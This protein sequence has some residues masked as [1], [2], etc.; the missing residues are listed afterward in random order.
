MQQLFQDSIYLVTHFGKSDLFM[1]FI[2]NS[3]WEEVTAALFIDQII[4]DKLNI[5][6]RVF[7]VKLKDLID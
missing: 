1:T 2:A 7:R 3:R 6:A 4:A 5:I